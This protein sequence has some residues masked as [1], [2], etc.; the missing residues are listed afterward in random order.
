MKTELAVIG[1]GPAGMAAIKIAAGF[2]V[3]VTVVD[4]QGAAGGQFL[5]QPPPQFQVDNW[6]QGSTY[7]AGKSQIAK[8]QDLPEIHWKM[9]TTVAGI[10][11]SPTADQGFE[12]LLDGFEHDPTDPSHGV[13]TQ[14]LHADTVLLAPGCF[15]MPVLFPGWNLPGVM[16]AGGIQA[17]VKSQQ[18]VPGERFLFAGSHPLQLVVADQIIRA[19]GQVA[20]VLFAQ[21]R[22]TA[23]KL[24]S[25]P[26]VLLDS[27]DKLI[28]TA[29]ILRRLKKAGVPVKFGQTLVKANGDSCL[30]SVTTAAVNDDGR[31]AASGHQDIACDRL[32]ICFG[33]LTSSELARQAGAHCIWDGPRGGFLASASQSM[34]SSVDNLYVAGEIT[35]VAGSEV[36]ALE[37][38][39]AAFHIMARL[40][41]ISPAK[42]NNLAAP[43]RRKL[44]AAMG[45]AGLLSHLSWPGHELLD[46]LMTES[47]IVCKCEEVTV[48]ELTMLLKS[49]PHIATANAAKLLSRV[50][51]GLCQGRYCHYGL[52]RIIAR[53]RGLPEAAVG[54]FTAR[55]PSKPL[56]IDQLICSAEEQI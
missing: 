17:F 34:S 11:P 29:A 48:G 16:A 30:T 23:L 1:A 47:T 22:R 28:Q 49:H 35:G 6:L 37:G 38:Q 56:G 40:G 3:S 15:D 53:Q 54:G 31:L 2:D 55:F 20:G 43:V 44:K 52:T 5:R 33:F 14:S 8:V 4:E 50:G 36:A 10:L 45:F 7:R 24:L 21:P 25:K 51:M 32:G 41:K 42:A 9:H 18:F 12:L 19:G 13:G 26:K 27:G 39:I 46:Q